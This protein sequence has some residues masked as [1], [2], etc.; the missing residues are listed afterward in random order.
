MAVG[1]V[2]RSH[3]LTGTVQLE[4]YGRG[5]EGRLRRT[6]RYRLHLGDA[7]LNVTPAVQGMIGSTV[8]VSLAPLASRAEADRWRGALLEVPKDERAPLCADTFYVDDLIGCSCCIK[9]GEPLGTVVDV[10]TYPANDVLVVRQGTREWL[11]PAVRS[12]V[13]AVDLKRQRIELDGDW[14]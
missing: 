14:S 10:L 5:G 12:T 6:G 9:G 7:T 3:G 11:V 4:L 1:I 8:L 13:L 2:R